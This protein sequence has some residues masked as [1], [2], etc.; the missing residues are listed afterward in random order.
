MITKQAVT[1]PLV[2]SESLDVQ[3]MDVLPL[4]LIAYVCDLQLFTTSRFNVAH[5]SLF[6]LALWFWGGRLFRS[7]WDLMLASAR[8]GANMNPRRHRRF[9]PE[10]EIWEMEIRDRSS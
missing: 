7:W 9:A 6:A 4:S 8:T 1:L 5:T 10:G 2:S 3:L